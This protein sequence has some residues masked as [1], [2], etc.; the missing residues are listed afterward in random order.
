MPTRAPHLCNHP[1]CPNLTYD[2]FCAEHARQAEQLRGSPSQRGYGA[3]HQRKRAA[4]LKRKP[5]C[6][7]PFGVHGDQPVRSTDRDHRIPLSQGGSD[8]ESNEQA[9]CHSC[10]SRKTALID[11][12]FGREG[13]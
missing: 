9:L 5:Y 12:G 13:A 6:E 1:G 3:E 4:L 10:H 8:D 7:D 2:R 11:G